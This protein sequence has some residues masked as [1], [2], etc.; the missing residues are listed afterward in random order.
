MENETQQQQ[1]AAAP[2]VNPEPVKSS[3]SSV[4]NKKTVAIVV[5]ILIIAAL[6]YIYR[7]VFVAA[8]V[9]GQPISRLAVIRELEKQAGRATL[10][11]M[12]N[13]QIVRDEIAKQGI[14][15]ED[16]TVN[17]EIAAIEAQ[18]T[19]QGGTLAAALMAQGMNLDELKDQI[20][21]Q[22]QVEQLLASKMNVTD[23]EVSAYITENKL[24][25]AEGQSEDAF[26][27][28]I[29]EQLVAAQLSL[30]ASDWIN[31]LRSEASV[32]YYVNY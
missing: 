29:R 15:V 25:P 8:T 9:N 24:T 3:A 32:N 6:A 22:K 11:A 18:I 5:I 30:Q 1:P 17:Q 31:T 13:E 23:E 4:F 26:K 2:A 21:L 20:L 16:E 27:G 19:S 14:V 28:Q 7:G 12:V 10:D